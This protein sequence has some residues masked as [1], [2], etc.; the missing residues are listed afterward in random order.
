MRPRVPSLALRVSLSACLAF[1]VAV[2]VVAQ[3]PA[4]P[5]R[6]PQAV[7]I[8]G[9]TFGLMVAS[10][11]AVTD[12]VATGTIT[13]SDGT[14]GSLTLKTI[15]P[16]YLRSEISANGQ[17]L[18]INFNKFQGYTVQ[19][20]SNYTLP[21]SLTKYA[22]PTF[23]PS[24]SKLADYIQPNMNLVYVG[25]ETLNTLSVYHIHMWA[26]PT[27]GTP[28]ALEAIM[29][30]VHFYI[31]TQT[32]LLVKTTTLLISP[33][34][35]EN[36]VPLDTYF[37]NVQQIGPLMVPFHITEFLRGQK[38]NEITLSSVQLNTGLTA[39]NFQ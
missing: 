17:Q 10:G 5:Q 7:A 13:L 37:D 34:A 21:F 39:S 9:Q 26:L 22:R 28:S 11:P 38:F 33:A 14:S 8:L 20:G 29:S 25:I 30:D 31:N 6:D 19:G 3:T 23:I 2:P 27:D 24:F 18:I 36:H 4:T 15:G 35:I 12:A 16:N 32:G 1:V